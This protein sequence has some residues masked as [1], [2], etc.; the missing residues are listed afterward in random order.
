[1]DAH[2]HARSNVGVHAHVKSNVG[3]HAHVKNNVDAH[4]HAKNNVDAHA[5]LHAIATEAREI[6]ID[7]VS[8]LKVI[9]SYPIDG[10]YPIYYYPNLNL[11]T[12]DGEA[13]SHLSAFDDFSDTLYQFFSG[14]RK[15]GALEKAL[16]APRPLF[17]E[18]WRTCNLACTYCYA[19]ADLSHQKKLDAGKL[20]RL[21]NKYPFRGALIFGGEPLLDDQFLLE[22]YNSNQWET[23][24]FSTNGIYL[25]KKTS[26]DLIGLRKVRFQVSL[27]PKEWSYRITADG[28][29]QFN[30]LGQQLRLLR[31]KRPDFRVTI[32]PDAPYIPI[33]HLVDGLAN[34]IGSFHF[35]A[36]FWPAHGASPVAWYE[37]WIQESYEL[38]RDDHA[39]KYRG[40]LPGF[41]IASYFRE[42]VQKGF[43]F[44]NCN[45]AHGSI[46]VGPDGRLH[47]CHELAIIESE[48]DD[49]SSY[50]DAQEIDENKRLN[51]VYKWSN[52]MNNSICAGCLARYVCG[53]ICFLLESPNAACL[54]LQGALQL[55]LTEMVR[56]SPQEAMD[57]AS[58][59]EVRFKY[60]YSMR[61]ELKKEVNS[62]KWKLLASGELPIAEAV[63]LVGRFY[64]N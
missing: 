39:G 3:V 14:I 4:A 17:V 24:F 49:I 33:K 36:S 32:P 63:E 29:K 48:L 12:L 34:A 26:Q 5:Q 37:N 53:G 23:F 56:Y 25:S 54:F 57:L 43:R 31:D 41:C 10:K 62:E 59:S 35:T 20:S 9:K 60:L 7:M 1:M 21:I 28:E 13:D 38:V 45:A 19:E 30:L 40:K 46:A 2:V 6:N 47:G 51:L 55:V 27:E 42:L 15:L 11:L 8:R 22:L 58:R 64:A 52:G 61:E 44:F 18:P 16:Q 50:D